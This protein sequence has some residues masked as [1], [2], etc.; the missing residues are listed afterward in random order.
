MFPF[1][2]V[3]STGNLGR[4]VWTSIQMEE[5]KMRTNAADSLECVI[6]DHSLSDSGVSWMRQHRDSAP[7][8]ILFISSV[9]WAAPMGNGKSSTHLEVRKESSN[10]RLTVTSLQE[11]DQGNYYFIINCNRM[12]HFSSSLLLHLPGQHQP[13]PISAPS[14]WAGAPTSHANSAPCPSPCR[15]SPQCLC[16]QEEGCA[17][18]WWGPC[19]SLAFFP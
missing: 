11:Q 12:L 14:A 10:Y 9:S 7:Q 5:P 4:L 15:P 2:T 17:D 19:L 1:R 16:A 8:F 3:T 13:H 6:S 18:G